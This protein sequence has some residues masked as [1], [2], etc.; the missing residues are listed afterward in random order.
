MY[1][2]T[3]IV[4]DMYRV[5]F[6]IKYRRDYLPRFP[7]NS[8]HGPIIII[9]ARLP[10]CTRVLLN[11]T[12]NPTFGKSNVL[13][14]FRSSFDTSRSN[15]SKTLED[16]PEKTGLLSIFKRPSF[17]RSLVNIRRLKRSFFYSARGQSTF[18]I[19]IVAV[20]VCVQVRRKR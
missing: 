12:S 20:A 10:S 8:V 9:H 18:E 11:C 6:P 2:N 5:I 15:E 16:H 19:L 17:L 14:S 3:Y 13:M 7:T 4:A 1:I